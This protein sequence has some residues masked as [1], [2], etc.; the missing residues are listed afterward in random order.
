MGIKARRSFRDD[1][2]EGSVLSGRNRPPT[3]AVRSSVGKQPRPDSRIVDALATGIACPES[4]IAGQTPERV[5]V[6]HAA[7]RGADALGRLAHS[8][9]SRA[10]PRHIEDK[11]GSEEQ[12][13]SF[14]N[15]EDRGVRRL[16]AQAGQ[17][18]AADL[19]GEGNG[20]EQI[21]EQRKKSLSPEGATAAALLDANEGG[22]W[23]W[24]DQSGALETEIPGPP[25]FLD[26]ISSLHGR[27]LPEAGAQYRDR[28][29]KRHRSRAVQ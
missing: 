24:R 9:R 8:R 15:H 14:R 7:P 1:A 4:T 20:E 16:C 5:R 10:A 3:V 26:G 13:G 29:L 25:P 18:T 6:D 11:H 23:A 17:T 19:P 22:D 12:L 28:G 21:R 27:K 2:G